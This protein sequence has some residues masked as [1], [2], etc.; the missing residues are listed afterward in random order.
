MSKVGQRSNIRVYEYKK[1]TVTDVAQDLGWLAWTSMVVSGIRG[2]PELLG[3]WRELRAASWI[4]VILTDVSMHKQHP[5]ALET[6]KYHLNSCWNRLI[7]LLLFS[8]Q[9]KHQWRLTDFSAPVNPSGSS[10]A[11]SRAQYVNQGPLNKKRG[12]TTW[13]SSRFHL[14]CIIN[15]IPFG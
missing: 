7:W 2:I 13:C 8:K 14:N 15:H 6:H 10:C 12:N 1:E 11:I 5:S 9:W 4:C 3:C